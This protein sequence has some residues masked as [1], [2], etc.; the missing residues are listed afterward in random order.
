MH[1]AMCGGAG[2]GQCT[3]G[4]CACEAGL[5]GSVCELSACDDGKGCGPHGTCTGFNQC[6]C[7]EGFEGDRCQRSSCA[8]GCSPKGTCLAG[9]CSCSVGWHGQRCHMHSQA[10]CADS[11][12]GVE[13][14]SCSL[15][16]TGGF[17]PICLCKSKF[18]GM[19]CLTSVGDCGTD[20]CNGGGVCGS[21]SVCSC[22]DGY[23]GTHCETITCQDNCTVS[24]HPVS[25]VSSANGRCSASAGCICKDGFSGAQCNVECPSRCHGHGEC[26]DGACTCRDGYGDYDCSKLVMDTYAE[27]LM[28]G[29]QGFYPVLLVTLVALMALILFCLVGYVV[30]RWRGRFGTAA[31]PMWEY[32]AK[33][34]RNAPLFEPI[35]AVSAATQTPPPPKQAN[36]PLGRSSRA[37]RA[38]LP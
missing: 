11:C 38:N 27:V 8:G 24:T 34:W 31:I 7:E 30:N 28:G 5:T 16:S 33:T 2:K 32:Y 22:Y 37:S 9:V 29:L 25:G 20:G 26:T 10:A 35:F 36:A 1:G 6:E 3:M 19:T 17:E 21:D 14:G 4:A 23:A 18:V 15:P 13:R 12:G